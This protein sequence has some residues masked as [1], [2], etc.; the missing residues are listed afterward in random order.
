MNDGDNCDELM[1]MRAMVAKIAIA[2][3]LAGSVGDDSDNDDTNND[4]SDV[5]MMLVLM[6]MIIVIL[7]L[8]VMMMMI[9]TMMVKAMMMIV[10]MMMMMM[11]LMMLLLMI[12]IMMLILV[13]LMLILIAMM[14]KLLMMVVV[15]LIVI[16]VVKG[17]ILTDYCY[18]Y[19]AA[20]EVCRNVKQSG[21]KSMMSS[22]DTISLSQI[23]IHYH[24]KRRKTDMI[25]YQ[26]LQTLGTQTPKARYHYKQGSIT[27][28]THRK[29]Q[30]KLMPY[31]QLEVQ[32][33][34][35]NQVLSQVL[36]LSGDVR[37]LLTY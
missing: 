5:L 23:R 26:G 29:V 25:Q 7:L 24:L 28:A 37:Q 11:I 35:Y 1:L 4:D 32:G 22:Q 13:L 15:T 19:L 30:L 2:M 14:M 34:P 3:M 9:M 33:Q 27:D 21:K 36:R 6:L 8:L 10:M 12:V 18:S 31:R 17:M 16:A 20:S